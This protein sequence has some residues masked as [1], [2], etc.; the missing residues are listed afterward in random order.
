[1]TTGRHARRTLAVLVVGVLALAP[2]GAIA[3]SGK[4]LASF[5]IAAGQA[6]GAGTL[7]AEDTNQS[8]SYQARFA[9][10]VRPVK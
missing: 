5:T 8:W 2:P 1:M 4:A 3:Q 6:T 9:A 7:T 10:P